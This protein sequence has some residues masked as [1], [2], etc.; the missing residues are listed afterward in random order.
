MNLIQ[1]WK[2]IFIAIS[3]TAIPFLAWDVFFTVRQIWGFNPKYL[4]DIYFLYL[5]LEEWLFFWM[6]PYASLFIYYSLQFFK[7]IWVL[8]NQLL[9]IITILILFITFGIVI[10]HYDKWYTLVNYATLWFILTYAFVRKRYLLKRFFV[11]YLIVLIPF[12]LVN[13]TLTGMWTV[14]PI[15]WYNDAENLGL[16][17]ITIPIEDFAYAF[18]MLLLSLIII[19]KQVNIQWQNNSNHH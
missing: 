8:S 9:S 15:V 4:L 6:I 5:P 1:W 2:P 18:S 7:P 12:V 13:G 11:A 17:F 14:E 16:R 10:L 3:L 19:D